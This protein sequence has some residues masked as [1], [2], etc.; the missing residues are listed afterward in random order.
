MYVQNLKLFFWVLCCSD[1]DTITLMKTPRCSL[2][3]QDE[4]SQT[5]SNQ[6][7]A[8]MKR[9]RRAISAWTNRNMN[10]RLEKKKIMIHQTA[11][12]VRIFLSFF[13]VIFNWYC[14][15]PCLAYSQVA[16]ISFFI[17][18]VEGN[19][20]LTSLL[21][22]KSVGWT[23]IPQVPRGHYICIVMNTFV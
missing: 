20:S 6:W 11:L 16:F 18:S 14:L 8:N 13:L 15:L 12:N 5:P 9:R 2:P 10:W 17:P 23:N 7:R 21:R 1:E 3:D 19:D 4:P 22:F